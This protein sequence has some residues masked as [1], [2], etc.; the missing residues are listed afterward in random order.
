MI[1]SFCL[2]FTGHPL[3]SFHWRNLTTNDESLWNVTRIHDAGHSNS[4]LM[5]QSP[6]KAKVHSSSSTHTSPR[7]LFLLQSE[8]ITVCY[9]NLTSP[10]SISD[11]N[12]TTSDI[13]NFIQQIDDNATINFLSINV[14]VQLEWMWTL[15]PPDQTESSKECFDTLEEMNDLGLDYGFVIEEENRVEILEK[16]KGF[17]KRI[18]Y[19]YRTIGTYMRFGNGVLYGRSNACFFLGCVYL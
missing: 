18:W 3:F 14:N 12:L 17:C 4:S 7:N 16:V 8:F 13:Y 2:Y 10:T 9:G 15:C 6:F 11:S 1:A 19:I 5:T